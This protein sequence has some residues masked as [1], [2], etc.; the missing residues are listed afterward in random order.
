PDIFPT[1]YIALLRAGE[2]SGSM[3]KILTRLAEQMEQE[4]EFRGKI[5]GALLYPAIVSI[6]MVLIGLAMM[7]L[8]IPR[9]AEVYSTLGA[10][11]PLP[12]LILIFVSGI[13]QSTIIFMPFVLA[14]LIRAFGR[15]K[16]T[17]AGARALSNLGYRLP[18]F[19]PLN[20]MVTFAIMLR[21]FGALV[22]SGIPILDALKI[23]KDT[24]GNNVYADG[25]AQ[26]AIQV[27]KGSRLSIP[28]QANKSFP[29]IIGQ[30][31][32]IGEETGKLDEV[33]V[34]LSIYFEQESDQRIKNLT[35][36]LEPIMIIVMG[37]G[38]AGLA[39]AILLP[40]FNLVNVIK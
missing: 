37:V 28:L 26:A 25:L 13:I 22:G 19:G 15:F 29:P 5:K 34:K 1:I 32:A 27:E 39:L 7:I 35:T 33:L 40:M 8:V 38:V 36:A 17:P 24:V 2:A 23:T 3:D 11:L 4:R 14:G 18:V 6:A 12:T 16:R 9:I 21:T 20:K 30:M 10:D 31:V